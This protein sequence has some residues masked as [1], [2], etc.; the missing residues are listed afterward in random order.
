MHLVGGLRDRETERRET[1]EQKHARER[2]TKP[3]TERGAERGRQAADTKRSRERGADE[4]RNRTGMGTQ[5]GDI[6]GA[7]KWG[8]TRGSE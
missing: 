7:T 1:A 2:G 6:G 5:R 3:E 4:R 8:E